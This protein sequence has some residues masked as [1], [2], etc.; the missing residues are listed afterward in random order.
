MKQNADEY[1]YEIQIDLSEA[2]PGMILADNAISS[3]GSILMIS[4]SVLTE[5]NI[6]KLKASKSENI[7]VKSKKPKEIPE[8]TNT[9]V[10]VPVE[11]QPEF[12]EF[13]ADYETGSVEMKKYLL[14]IGDGA[15]I[16]LDELFKLTDGIMG[17]LSCKSNVL[18]FLAYLKDT[19]EHTFTHS[20]NVALLC[21][22]F[23]RW[24]NY[25]DKD[26]MYLTT[27]G[28]LHDV[29]KTKVPIE[30]L[31]K[32]GR[33]TDSEF[34]IMKS[35]TVLGYRILENHDIP[36][37]IKLASLMHHEKIN[38]KGYPLGATGDKINT[39]T[40]IV[41]IC[42]I[43]DAMTANRVYRPK[44]CPFEVIRTFERSVYGELDT[45]FL[46]V[47]LQNIAYT[48]IDSPVRLSDDREGTVVFINKQNLSKPMI[49]LDTG[50]IVDLSQYDDLSIAAL[51]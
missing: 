12:K 42:D 20:N 25:D 14:A 2:E 27:A 10:S 4:G 18:T 17:K 8:R 47:F 50:D 23:S 6:E 9:R 40:K 26:T 38:G 11:E 24:L 5:S 39:I 44:V 45:E 34:Q 3:E 49:K 21:N 31:N 28:I 37:N 35:H 51:I 33:L 43:Y 19:D 15:E 22:L 7:L 41:S 1:P 13:A 32:K 46:L 29:G 16:K 30:V 36:K 48:Y